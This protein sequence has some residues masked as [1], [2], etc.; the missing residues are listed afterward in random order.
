MCP[1]EIVISPLVILAHRPP[2]PRLEG[3]PDDSGV[4]A[5]SNVVLVGR[6]GG[7]GELDLVDAVG[8]E[9]FDEKLTIVLLFQIKVPFLVLWVRQVLAQLLDFLGQVLQ[10]AQVLLALWLLLL[11]LLLL[12]NWL[13]IGTI[14]DL[15]LV[16]LGLFGCLL[17]LFGIVVFLEILLCHFALNDHQT[18]VY[19]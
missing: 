5:L 1:H 8:P 2:K 18:G 3:R 13:T 9:D 17:C 14:L 19:E 6:E 15:W 4:V 10:A 7:G 11:N 16:L 12:V